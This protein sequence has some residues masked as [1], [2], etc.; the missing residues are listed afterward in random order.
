MF[1]TIDEILSG[2]YDG[3]SVKLRGWLHHMRT[4]GGILFLQLRE[5]TG[6]IQCTLKKDAVGPEEFER[7]ATIPVEST[8]EISGTVRKDPRAPRG[9][10]IAGDKVTILYPA[11]EGYPIAKKYH[12]P[13]FLLDNRHLFI[14][15]P[16][17]Q[18]MLR[19][20]AHLIDALRRWL[21]DH[22]Y[23]E[24]HVPILVNAA[25]EGG[26]TLFE[27]KYFDQKAY[28]TQSWQL[29]AEAMI[30]S[31]GKIF[32]L[33]PSFRAEKSRTRRHLTEYWHLEVEEPWLDL[34]GLM[35][36]EEQLVSYAC[37]H[38]RETM[39]E[40]LKLIGRNPE[41]LKTVETPFPRIRYDEA[42]KL[43]QKT[44]PEFKWGEDMG[45][46]EEKVVTESFDKPFF[47]SHFPKGVKAFYHLPD[48][49]DPKVTLSTDLLAP[50]GFGEITGG[51]QR[52]HDLAQLLDRIKEDGLKADDYKWYVEL[53]RYGTVPHSGFGMG[54]ERTLSWICKLEH[55]RDSIAFPRLINRVYP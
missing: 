30:S 11:E 40:E 50:E 12:G 1:Q 47:V 7:L 20:R 48:P 2:K 53:R 34:D 52:I 13:D 21:I 43:V 45:W 18:A 5:G 29:Y 23:L 22:G 35:V 28:L 4:G 17:V 39:P 24:V 10:E 38:V 41:D 6:V 42:V 37:Q 26:S 25:V 16:K 8:V 27:V 33:A 31:V 32:T 44:N 54:I 15:D 55:I 9:Y 3:K 49:N 51:G 14:R 46:E 19:V 36:L